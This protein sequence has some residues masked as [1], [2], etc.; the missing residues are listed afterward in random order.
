MRNIEIRRGRAT[1]RWYG[2]AL[3]SIVLLLA[4]TV[5]LTRAPAASLTS[6]SAAISASAAPATVHIAVAANF[7]PVQAEIAQRFSRSTG[8]EV[9]VSIGAT[10]QLYA[11]IRNGAPYDILLAA[12]AE[13]PRLLEEEGIGV[14]GM[15][16]TYAE[17]RLVLW[18]PSFD[19]VRPDGADI[20]EGR[21]RRLAIANPRTAPYGAAAAEVL[22]GLGVMAEVAPRLVRGENIGQTFQFVRSGAAELGFVA[23]AQVIREP[24]ASYW[25]IPCELYPPII[26]DAVLLGPGAENPAA[27]E[28]LRYLRG[29]EARRVIEAYGYG[30]GTGNHPEA[31]PRGHGIRP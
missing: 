12:D 17:G 31:L 14:A 4:A 28:Y 2:T 26:Q 1:G 16:F 5:G 18:G 15:R 13:R 21:F 22:Q 6:A 10:G 20:R 19:S 27:R 25:L 8:H 29:V 3:H 30:V 9:R 24:R 23:L 11:Q 7:A